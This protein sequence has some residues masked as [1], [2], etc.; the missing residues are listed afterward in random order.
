MLDGP[1]NEDLVRES[2]NTHVICSIDVD[3]ADG[4]VVCNVLRGFVEYGDTNNSD[5]YKQL[6]RVLCRNAG[7]MSRNAMG[8]WLLRRLVPGDE[9]IESMVR[10]PEVMMRMPDLALWLTIHR[11]GKPNID[12][13]LSTETIFI[14][15]GD[16]IPHLGQAVLDMRF[17][18]I[19]GTFYAQFAYDLV[20]R[21]NRCTWV[22]PPKSLP[23]DQRPYVSRETFMQRL[24]MFIGVDLARMFF[25]M[26]N[27]FISGAILPLCALRHG[28]RIDEEEELLKYARVAWQKVSCD[29]FV[30][31][32]DA[33]D[34]IERYI[35]TLPF[36]L[37]RKPLEWHEKD[38]EYTR[39]GRTFYLVSE[40]TEKPYHMQ[41][42]A[43]PDEE[44]AL[45]VC[46][47]NHFPFVRCWYDMHGLHVTPSC[48]ASWFTRFID[49]PPFFGGNTSQE[50]RRRFFVKYAMRGFGFDAGAM[51]GCKLP[52]EITAWIEAWG[53]NRPLPWYSP[54]YQP[55]SWP[56]EY[57]PAQIRRILGHD[58]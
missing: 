45:G 52:P 20:S 32:N 43:M 38:R 1:F 6:L 27:C 2:Y 13:L 7:P 3:D 26:P 11:T 54:L 33:T 34:E 15:R 30:I 42:I 12:Y 4:I 40:D 31:G 28:G 29:V 16:L 51:Q 24:R 9:E 17:F 22:V 10:I 36:K 50:R 56:Q 55:E 5:L 18:S 8:R 21:R 23:F 19:V 48:L 39:K 53:C 57:T 58:A 44:T 35:A 49:L 14:R 47:R 25:H 41:I 37:T 46:A